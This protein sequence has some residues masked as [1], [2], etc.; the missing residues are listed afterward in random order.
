M[1]F[2]KINFDK[3]RYSVIFAATPFF[4]CS[5]DHLNSWAS[6]I[7]I[8]YS[9]LNKKTYLSY[10][11]CNTGLKGRKN[12]IFRFFLSFYLIK[13]CLVI[14]KLWLGRISSYLIF[15]IWQQKILGTLAISNNSFIL[16]THN[17]IKFCDKKLFYN[18]LDIRSTPDIRLYPGYSTGYRISSIN[19]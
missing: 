9:C 13:V 16:Q 18:M 8:Y 19:S 14:L 2:C 10:S 7:R 17:C 5:S 3:I 4:Q 11:E 15:N 6:L 1:N 12:V